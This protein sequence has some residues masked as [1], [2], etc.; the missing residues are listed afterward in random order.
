MIKG[1]L[2]ILLLF[3]ALGLVSGPGFR[4]FLTKLLGLPNRDR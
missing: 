3:V 2:V 4:R 1:V